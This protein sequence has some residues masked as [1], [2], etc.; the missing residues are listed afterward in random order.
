MKGPDHLDFKLPGKILNLELNSST[1][2][3]GW[4]FVCTIF[5]SWYFMTFSLYNLEDS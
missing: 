3:P 5:L 2:C 1:I 4:K